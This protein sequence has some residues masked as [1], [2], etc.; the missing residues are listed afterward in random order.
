MN[1]RITPYWCL[2]GLW[3]AAGAAVV[4]GLVAYVTSWP[5]GAIAGTLMGLVMALGLSP[6]PGAS[7][8]GDEE[9]DLSERIRRSLIYSGVKGNRYHTE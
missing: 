3:C 9:L 6:S 5:I 2:A 4:G 8:E 7:A 1:K